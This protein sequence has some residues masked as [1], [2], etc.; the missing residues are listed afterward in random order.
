M[1]RALRWKKAVRVGSRLVRVSKCERFEVVT[2]QMASGRAGYF[3]ARAYQAKHH[4]G[5]KKGEQIGPLEETLENALDAC[6]WE[7]DPSWEPD[8]NPA[9]DIK[10]K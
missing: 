4:S 8:T 7:N 10:K 3:N 2:R 9:P 6:E 5:P 1:K